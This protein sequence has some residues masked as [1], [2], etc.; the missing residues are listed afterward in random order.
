MSGRALIAIAACLLLAVVVVYVTFILAWNPR[1]RLVF[2]VLPGAYVAVF[3]ERVFRIPNNG[4]GNIV[5]FFVGNVVFWFS[6]FLL[7]VWTVGRY[8]SHRTKGAS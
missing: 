4:V 1:P 7:I 8:R 2:M 6:L 3:I 5:A